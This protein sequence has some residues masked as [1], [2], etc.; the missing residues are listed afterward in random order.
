[1]VVANNQ[2][3]M[4]IGDNVNLF[5]WTYV[6]N[7]VKAH[8]LPADKIFGPP[9]S[10]ESFSASN[11]ETISLTTHRKHTTSSSG[12]RS[13]GP[14]LEITAE[15]DKSY[16]NPKECAQ[17]RAS[18]RSKF[19]PL[20]AESIELEPSCPLQVTAQAFFVTNGEPMHF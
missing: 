20:V 18:V 19:D 4:Q 14:A 3:R 9:L 6:S 15:I 10:I 8:L 17:P 13:P 1:M 5:D 2:I 12:S 11:L 7:V 16:S